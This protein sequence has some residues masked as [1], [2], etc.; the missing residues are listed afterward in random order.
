[1]QPHASSLENDK[2]KKLSISNNIIINNS[3][4]ETSDIIFQM[5]DE[6]LTQIGHVFHSAYQS[7]VNGQPQVNV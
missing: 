7:I 2:N 6:G 3:L 5:E 1:M 4:S